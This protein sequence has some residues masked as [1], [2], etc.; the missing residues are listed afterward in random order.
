MMKKLFKFLLLGGI[1]AAPG[2]TN[3]QSEHGTKIPF[4][5]P[6]GSY[7]SMNESRA[8]NCGVDT[9]LYPYLKEL[10]F[11]APSDSFFVDAMV[12]N[13]R[14]AAQG[15]PMTGTVNVLGVQFWGAAYST[16]TAPQTLQV[17]AYLYAVDASYLPVSILDS[18]VVTIT[19][20]YQFYSAMFAAPH[21]VTGNFSVGVKCVPNDTLAVITN[22]AGNSWSTPNYGEGL[23]WRRFGSGAWN[24]TLAF[25]GQDLEYM[26]FPIVDYSISSSF[27]PSATS[28]CQGETVTYTNNSSSLLGDR[29][30]NLLAFD[31]YWSAAIND[32]TFTWNYGTDA[33]WTTSMN[34]S[35]TFTNSGTYTTSLSAEMV[36]YFST[37]ED[38]MTVAVTVNPVYNQ[39]QSASICAGDSYSFGSQTLA[40]SGVYTETFQSMSNCDSTV[41]LNLNVI[42]ID[43]SVTSMGAM[44]SANAT[45]VVYQWIDCNS[46]TAIIGATGQTYTATVNGDYAVVLGLGSCADTSACVNVSSVGIN[47]ISSGAVANVFPNPSSGSFVVRTNGV[48]ADRIIVYNLLGEIVSDIIPSSLSTA[49]SMDEKSKGV[50]YVS[51]QTS[52]GSTVIKM[53]IK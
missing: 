19:E 38:T 49:V 20:D 7:K 17:K 48:I 50:Y 40:T 28:I 44:I 16:S 3:A 14:T 33:T 13:V 15:Y 39:N 53:M 45:G 47:N 24:T 4:T 21:S 9:I 25:F 23:S 31:D 2:V 41:V 51:I 43:N 1:L 10:A 32:S 46:N 8:T 37:C 12:G 52:I 35:K 36:G 5:V 6:S 30:F 22:N 26:I 27:V 34:G 11:T 29:A 42:T 18:A